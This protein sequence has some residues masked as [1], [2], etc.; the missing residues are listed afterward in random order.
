MLQQTTVPAVIPYFEK[1]MLKYPTIEH[2]AEAD[3]EEVEKE[4]EV[5]KEELKK[6]IEKDLGERLK[7]LF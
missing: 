3:Q 7:K 6:K 4:V 1:W 2:L 5:K